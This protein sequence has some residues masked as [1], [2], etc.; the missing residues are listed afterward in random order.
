MTQRARSG[1]LAGQLARYGFADPAKAERLISGNAVRALVAE[2]DED[3]LLADLAA[4]ADPDQALLLLDRLLDS[5]DAQQRV[6]LTSILAADEDTRRRAIDVLGMSEAL[7]EFL[8]KH[9]EHAALLADGQWLAEAPSASQMR[10]ALLRAV[11]ADPDAGDPVATVEADAALDALRVA[12]RAALLGIATRDLSGLAR[13]DD[14]AAWLT[15]LA[16]AVLAT[17]L[18]IARASVPQADRDL[19]RVA[20]IAMGKAGGRELNYVSDVD[21]IF[22]AEP[23]DGVDEARALATATSIATALMRACS[24]TTSEGTIWE[25]DPNLRPEGRQ[26][27]VV[28]TLASHVEYY[29]RWAKTWEFQALLKARA[30]AGDPTLGQAYVDAVQPFVWAAAA[31]EGFVD[32]V[33]AMRRRVEENLPTRTAEREIKLGP[34]GLR[35]IEF[36]VQLLQLVHGRS[37]DMLRSPNTLDA[38]DALAA[39]G[40][41]GRD[42]AATLGSAYRFLRTL[43]H[44]IQLYRLRRTHVMPEA[45]ADLRRLGRSLGFT[46]DPVGELT[47]QWRAHAREVRRLHEKLFYRPLLQAVARLDPGE[48]RLTTQAAEQRLRALGYADP[49]G[50]LRHLEALTAGVSRRAAIQRTLLPVML[51]WFADGPDPDAGL[52]GFRRVSDELGTTHWYLGLLRDES[53]AAER[54]A[55]I[56]SCSKYATE[57]MLAAPEHVALLAD[58]DELVPRPLAALLT[59]VE[60]ALARHDDPERAVA[61]IRALRRRELLRIAAAQILSTVDAYTGARA[62]SDIAQATITG[63]LQAAMAKVEASAGSPLPM[64]FCVIGMGR[65][66]GRELGFGSDADVMFVYEPNPGAD[67]EAAAK[68]ALAVATELRAL[69]MAASSDPPLEIDADLRPEGKQGPLVRSLESYRAYYARW[70]ASWEAQALLRALPVAGDVDLG[71]AF[72]AL[73][74]PIRYPADGLPD[75]ELREIRRLKARMEAERL[76]RGADPTLHTKLG[77]G[78][79][80][81][82]EWVVQTLSMEHGARMPSLRTTRTLD[83]LAAARDAGLL[84]REDHS[85]LAAAWTMATAVRG[86]VMLARD[87]AS[88]M[89]PTD[90]RERASVAFILGYP[91]GESMQMIEDYRRLTRRAR[92]VMERLFY[93]NE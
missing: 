57:L 38:L 27:A 68:A 60:A 86:A 31:R 24:A 47:K 33:Q 73:I 93:G 50:A 42:A 52:L 48:A 44:R 45:E 87:H 1:T 74:D 41:V 61:A 36:S 15:D 82:V 37:D 17:A 39:L 35:D 92:A 26:G 78:G 75:A 23:D 22:V 49:A 4:A 6:Q 83:C 63:A 16:D 7:G 30:A 3:A 53:V 69:L 77:R 62:L 64:R 8:A 59:E 66:G 12:Y 2:I 51:G 10:A 28:R 29:Q 91:L 58:D 19:V 88:D 79:L 5:A 20:V 25:V 65:F 13:I 40:Y 76:P 32:D 56:L 54:M 55:R 46:G 18:A 80:S 34:G 71:A 84:T 72:I 89:V 14:V 90:P 9:P 21:V 11:G 70:S 67:D 81:D 85:T 43:E